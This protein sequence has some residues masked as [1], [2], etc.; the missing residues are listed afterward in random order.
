MAQEIYEGAAVAVIN[1]SGRCI[2]SRQCVLGRPDA[3]V[4][5]AVGPWIRPDAVSAEEVIAVVERCPSGALGYERRDGGPAERPPGVN[6][7][8]LQQDGPL[9][10]YGELNIAGDASSFRATLCRCG[11]SQNKP[12]CDNAH[13]AAA[14]SAT[15]EPLAQDSEPLATRNGP[16]EITPVPNGPLMI[17]GSLEICAGLGRTLNRVQE[18]WLCRCGASNKKPYCDGSHKRIGFQ[19]P[20]GGAP[21]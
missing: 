12:Y 9:A 11:Q 20:G 13:I 2:H 8:R 21:G 16:L 4:P 1:R 18:T 19:A 17:K 5:N 14:F 3:F 6:A 15:A 7:V 10:F